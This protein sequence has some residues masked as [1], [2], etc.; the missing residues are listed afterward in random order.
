MY[1][2]YE[3]IRSAGSGYF[4]HEFDTQGGQSGSPIYIFSEPSYRKVFGLH[5]GDL[6]NYNT[7]TRINSSSFGFICNVLDEFTYTI[8]GETHNTRSSF[9][10]NMTCN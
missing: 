4:F 10:T 8:D 6:G 2:Q 3:E 5:E 9:F 7:A 1:R